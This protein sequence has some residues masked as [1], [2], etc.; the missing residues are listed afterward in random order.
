MVAQQTRL[1][2]EE[3]YPHVG[4]PAA[5]GQPASA[6]LPAFLRQVAPGLAAVTQN[7]V[8]SLEIWR[9]RTEQ[10]EP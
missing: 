3:T 8:T 1:I 7:G 9:G 10:E 2:D 5:R 6:P 4:D